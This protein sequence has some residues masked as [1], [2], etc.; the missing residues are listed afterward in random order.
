MASWSAEGA[1]CCL[2]GALGSCA[3]VV[4]DTPYIA[5]H[6]VV[7]DL[8]A[9][10]DG[11]HD[12]SFLIDCSSA[13]SMLKDT[14]QLV[15]FQSDCAESGADDVSDALGGIPN[16]AYGIAVELFSSYCDP[17]RPVLSGSE[18]IQA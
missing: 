7:I 17:G 8:P 12:F 9:P 6:G 14:A 5:A 3:T 11:G 16:D 15:Q 10:Y 4:G 2:A 18:D 1:A 13:Q